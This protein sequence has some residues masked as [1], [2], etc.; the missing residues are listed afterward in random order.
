MVPR[1]EHELKLVYLFM[2]LKM[3]CCFFVPNFSVRN[4]QTAFLLSP[5]I[6]RTW[7]DAN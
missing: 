2:M 4:N 5:R 6:V 7:S 1:S 3:I